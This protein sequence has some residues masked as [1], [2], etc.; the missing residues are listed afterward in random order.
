MKITSACLVALASAKEPSSWGEEE[1]ANACIY[2]EVDGV[3][4]VTT[5]EQLGARTKCYKKFSCDGGRNVMRKVNKMGLGSFG[6]GDQFCASNFIKFEY[7]VPRED[8]QDELAIEDKY[9]HT[10]FSN[11]ELGEWKTMDDDVWFSFEFSEWDY[12]DWFYGYNDY[13]GNDVASN[14]KFEIEIKCSEPVEPEP[15]TTTPGATTQATT[16]TP[17]ATTQAATTTPSDN[18]A[19]TRLEGARNSWEEMITRS[20]TLK[21]QAKERTQAKF[22]RLCD[23]LQAK[24]EKLI[25]AGCSFPAQNQNIFNAQ[26]VD[27]DDTCTTS[28]KLIQGN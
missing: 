25:A 2:D 26:F 13:M 17:G 16:T 27:Y 1:N 24:H 3:T 5:V 18:S 23:K 4:T 6:V 9:C 10:K 12:Y 15:E 19:Y 11:L 28:S 20:T 14:A 8:F 21:N 22:N 7:R